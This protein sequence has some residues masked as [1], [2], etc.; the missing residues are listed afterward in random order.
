MEMIVNR[1]QDG[2]ETWSAVAGGCTSAEI[3]FLVLNATSKY[4][5]VQAVMNAAPDNHYGLAISEVRFESYEN[6]NAEITAVYKGGSDNQSGGGGSVTSNRTEAQ[7]S[8]DCGGGTKHV[9]HAITQEQRFP[10]KIKG[11]FA[12]IGWN[13]KSGA[14]MEISGVDIPT[15]QLRETY[16][17]GIPLNELTVQ[18]K[19]MLAGLVGCVNAKSFKGWDSGEVM[20]LGASYSAPVSGATMA[21][22]T[23]NFSIQP[24]EADVSF[25]GQSIGDV[26]GWDYVWARSAA[27]IDDDGVPTTKVDSVYVAQVCKYADFNK[28]GL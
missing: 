6:G 4:E 24:N 2:S 27:S 16:T 9:T 25:A 19:R 8:F 14:D 1:L 12:A 28:L 21:T 13:G 20:F 5:A 17:I 11:T 15:A 7:M 22:V 23:F 18:Y 10:E 3:N 26:V